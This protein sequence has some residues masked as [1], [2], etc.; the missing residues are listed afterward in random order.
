MSEIRKAVWG[1]DA[2]L[3]TAIVTLQTL[4]AAISILVFVALLLPLIV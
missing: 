2:F 1:G 3:M 4:I